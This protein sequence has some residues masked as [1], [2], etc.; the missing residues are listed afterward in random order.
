M[1]S[2][3]VDPSTGTRRWCPPEPHSTPAP[4]HRDP[5]NHL[6]LWHCGV[7]QGWHHTVRSPRTIP[8][9]GNLSWDLLAPLGPP[10]SPQHCGVPQSRCQ[11]GTMGSPRTVPGSG[12]TPWGPPRAA[13]GTVKPPSVTFGTMGSEHELRHNEGPWGPVAQQGEGH[14]GTW[15]EVT[16]LRPSCAPT[17]QIKA[18]GLLCLG[19]LSEA[20]TAT[21]ILLFSHLIIAPRLNDVK[22]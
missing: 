13:P 9:I 17:E 2:P 1:G 3:R 6:L 14:L 12:T 15:Q 4:G 22:D 19:S 18:Q 20:Q 16:T 5:Q 7:T 21:V 10:E 8:G 11:L